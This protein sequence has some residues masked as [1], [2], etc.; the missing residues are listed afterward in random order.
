[1]KMSHIPLVLTR[2]ETLFISPNNA[3]R[4]ELLP[5]PTAPTTAT[6]EALGMR[7]LMFFKKGSVSFSPQEK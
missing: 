6:K 1:M 3:E 5:E 7:R 2:P 4:R